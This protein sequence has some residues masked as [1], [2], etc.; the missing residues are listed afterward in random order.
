[1]KNIK[2]NIKN[3]FE[4]RI[5]KIKFYYCVNPLSK[6]YPHYYDSF[7][8]VLYSQFWKFINAK[9]WCDISHIYLLFQTWSEDEF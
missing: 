8:Y 1:M 7:V 4:T 2:R 5:Q 6:N 3:R 9:K